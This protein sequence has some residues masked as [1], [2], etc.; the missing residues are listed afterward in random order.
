MLAHMRPSARLPLADDTSNADSVTCYHDGGDGDTVPR[1]LYYHN[2]HQNATNDQ[3]FI[4]SDKLAWLGV[5][6]TAVEGD[7][8][9]AVPMNS[10]SEAKILAEALTKK[11]PQKAIKLYSSE[12]LV[13]EKK[14]HFASVDAYW[15]KYDVLIYTPTVSA[16]VSFEQKH[17][18]KVFAYFTDQSCPA[19]TCIQMIGRIRDISTHQLFVCVIASGA[20]LPTTS[21]TI[22]AALFSKRDNLFRSY[23]N[24]GVSIEYN[25]RGEI[26]YHTS[27]Y[28]YLWLENTRIR[29]LS[30]NS[31]ALRFIQLVRTSGAQFAELSETE[32]EI[33]TGSPMRVG[34]IISA[35][36]QNISDAHTH[37][38]SEIKSVAREKIASARE[39][40][41]DDVTIIQDAFVA[42]QD[43]S[44]EDLAAFDKYKL[45]RV[46]DYPHAMDAKFVAI[47][48][49]SRIKRI[50]R[51]LARI[52]SYAGATPGDA[53]GNTSA[54]D[55][56]VADL[57]V[58]GSPCSEYAM[59][60]CDVWKYI[61]AEERACHEH[62]MEQ[63]ADHQDIGYHYVADQHRYALA[64]LYI[65]GWNGI[66]DQRHI[67]QVQL[68]VGIRSSGKSFWDL[69]SSA[70]IEFD[71]RKPRTEDV[72]SQD[73]EQLAKLSIKYVNQI[74]KIMYGTRV[75]TRK[76]DPLTFFITRENLFTFVPAISENNHIPLIRRGSG[77]AP[78]GAQTRVGDPSANPNGGCDFVDIL[79]DV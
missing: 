8:R 15:S 3:Y 21:T 31:F 19:E 78:T 25:R 17:F 43:V 46:Y 62:L 7:E 52:H 39:L 30:K 9:I 54:K 37:C 23:D 5:L 1:M 51:N 20:S 70:C 44:A 2:T 16:G 56:H 69:I 28:F 26:I 29:N 59:P 73:N 65:C 61:Q 75:I 53:L 35:E 58:R 49:Q 60:Q 79:G 27:D 4:T 47:Y 71:L 48:N 14:T 24:T 45:R 74:T 18:A 50:F 64:A 66:Y 76:Q 6:Y 32:Y 67:H 22:S 38:K 41:G 42:Q 40:D 72:T 12:T 36:L 10:L 68:L 77:E 57:L 55:S 33:H 11:Y 13:S 34:N 63:R